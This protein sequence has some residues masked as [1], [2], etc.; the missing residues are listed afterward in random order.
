[1]SQLGHEPRQVT[2]GTVPGH[3][4]QGTSSPCSG[5]AE[6]SR[7][8]GTSAAPTRCDAARSPAAA[9]PTWVMSPGIPT[10]CSFSGP[11]PTEV[12][13]TATASRGAGAALSR[14]KGTSRAA[15]CKHFP[16][17]STTSS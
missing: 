2:S 4:R 11:K 9:H 13:S 7:A 5:S 17:A 14:D 16:S 8:L 3:S 6:L 15:L 12:P 1:M 10:S